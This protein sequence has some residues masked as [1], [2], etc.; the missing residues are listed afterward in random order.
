MAGSGG[1]YAAAGQSSRKQRTRLQ[2]NTQHTL[3]VLA[4]SSHSKSEASGYPKSEVPWYRN[5]SRS[6]L[7]GLVL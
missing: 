2:Q 6:H 1:R 5:R 4:L 3:G 7:D